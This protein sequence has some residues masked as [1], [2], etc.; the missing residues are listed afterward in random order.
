[1][2]AV[3]WSGTE[4]KHSSAQVRHQEKRSLLGLNNDSS[5]AD[6]P[7]ALVEETGPGS[8]AGRSC[9]SKA[10]CQKTWRNPRW[11]GSDIHARKGTS[12]K[13][14]HCNQQHPG[15]PHGL[16]ILARPNQTRW[17]RNNKE[18]N[19]VGR[20]E[21]VGLT[22][23]LFCFRAVRPVRETGACATSLMLKSNR[24]CT[25]ERPDKKAR[26]C[27]LTLA[28]CSLVIDDGGCK[29]RS[30]ARLSVSNTNSN[31]L[32]GTTRCMSLSPL[33]IT[34]WKRRADAAKQP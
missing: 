2:S 11:L 30:W 19:E 16:H 28:R 3:L 5:G 24:S 26:G 25:A 9:T 13:A 12:P 18:V 31:R 23:R 33:S 21:V 22:K 4:D 14:G 1:M 15:A 32:G 7:G 6:I 20:N 8:K 17:F 34:H 27:T 10:G 29:V